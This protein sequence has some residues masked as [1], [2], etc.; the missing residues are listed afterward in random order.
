MS[1]RFGFLS[2]ANFVVVPFL[3]LFRLGGAYW[4]FGLALSLGSLP[5]AANYYENSE[6]SEEAITQLAWNSCVVLL[7]CSLS[8]ILTFFVTMNKKYRSTFWTLKRGKDVTLGHMNSSEDARRALIFIKSRRHW[9]QIEDKV[10]EWVRENWERWM[11]EKPKWLDENMK[12]KIP[13]EMIP[14]IGKEAIELE[15]PSPGLLQPRKSSR[16]VGITA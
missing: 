10:E 7:P 4:L 12:S 1:F 16:K 14:K 15:S 13:L 2:G 8:L 3:A 9:K 6:G 5:L 11:N